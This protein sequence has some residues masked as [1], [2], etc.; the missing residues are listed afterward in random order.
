MK[1]L[2]LLW[3]IIANFGL[4]KAQNQTNTLVA[5]CCEDGRGCSGSAYCTACKNCSG[6]KH[7]AKNGGTCGVCSSKTRY[8]SIS[9]SSNISPSKTRSYTIGSEIFVS[10]PTLN[11]REGPSSKY[12]IIEK[13]SQNEGLELIEIKGSWLKV[14]VKNSGTLGYVYSKYIK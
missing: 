9:T 12:K 1:Q 14:R 4:L 3:L 10:S 11:L 5:V 13:L 7:C 6:C 2:L 8:K